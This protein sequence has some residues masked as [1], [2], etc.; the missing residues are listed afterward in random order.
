MQADCFLKSSR[1]KISVTL[2]N[3]KGTEL[4]YAIKGVVQVISDENYAELISLTLKEMKKE[5]EL[6]LIP[7]IEEK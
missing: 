7:K 1:F 5:T 3:N 6:D 2:K 4:S